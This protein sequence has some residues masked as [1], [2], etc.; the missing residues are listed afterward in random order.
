MK[1]KTLSTMATSAFRL[2]S[3]GFSLAEVAIAVAIAAT[4]LVTLLGI[5][6][7]GLDSVRGAGETTSSA[8]IAS[9]VIGEIQLSDWGSKSGEGAS[10]R[11]SNLETMIDKRWFYDD[12]ANP[13]SS[14]GGSS[15]AMQ[16]RLAYVV[17]VRPAVS[18]QVYLPGAASANE[19][20]KAVLV[21][22]AIS[23]KATFDFA[24]PQSYRTYPAVLTRQFS[25]G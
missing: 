5:I 22:V 7:A 15:S 2:S 19:N 25:K 23:P 6:P 16:Y 17:R 12:Q 24:N 21:D 9:Q 4:G 10:A 13:I 8:R 14:V 18:P 11:W 3:K 1:L 20:M